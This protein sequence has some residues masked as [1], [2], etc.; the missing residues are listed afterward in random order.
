M[1]YLRASEYALVRRVY[2][3]FG[4]ADRTEVEFFNGG[5][6]INGR[7]TFDFLHQ[8]LRWPKPQGE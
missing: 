3:N 6:T 1:V 5:H 2:D 7:G 8:H 4:L